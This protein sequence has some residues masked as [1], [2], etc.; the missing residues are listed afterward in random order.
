M[1]YRDAWLLDVFTGDRL[2][3][4]NSRAAK[5]E[6]KLVESAREVWF[7]NDPIKEW[8]EKLYPAQAAKMHTVANGFDPDLVPDTHDRGPVT[9]RPLV[10]GYVGT[11]SPKVP[12]AEFVEGWQL[13]RSSSEELAGAKAKIY[14]YL[15]YYAQPRADMLAHDQQRVRGR[16]QLRG[17]GRQG[18]DRQGVRR[19]RRPA[20][21]ARQG[22]VRD[23]RQGVRVPGDRVADRVGARPG[24]RGVRRTARVIRCGSRCRR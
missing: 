11:V 24:E 20:A 9:D 4:P 17:P 15:G 13:A 16:G 8:H 22:A 14:G 18:G 19:V 2:H 23:E 10:F 5:W 3:E 6:K 1:D 21:D 12:L 7:V